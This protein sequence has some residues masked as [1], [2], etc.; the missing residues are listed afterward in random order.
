MNRFR[1]SRIRKS[2]KRRLE[3]WLPTFLDPFL[4]RRQYGRFQRDLRRLH[5]VLE[6]TPL[7][8]RYWLRGGL[9]LGWAREGMVLAHDSKDA[10]FGYLQVDRAR[11]LEALPALLNAGFKP[12]NIL[13]NNAG[14][15]TE[16]RVLRKGA[17]FEF[18]EMTEVEEEF[19]YFL[20]ATDPPTQ[21]RC[22][23]P[24]HGLEVIS[25]LDRQWCK[26]DRHEEQLDVMYGQWRIPDPEHNYTNSGAAIERT[27]WE[28]QWKWDLE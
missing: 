27:P 12:G 15:A 18:F 28:I 11:L 5:D 4:N 17:Q 10:D 26:P 24:R 7:A 22:R 6:T 9:L 3:P 20:Y 1:I 2:L 14:E 25:F 16:Y 8:G 19:E 13:R 23:L 21:V